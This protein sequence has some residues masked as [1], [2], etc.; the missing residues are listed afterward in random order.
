M[1]YFRWWKESQ[2]K[3]LQRARSINP[4]EICCNW[5]NGLKFDTSDLSR[6]L[7]VFHMTFYK[8]SGDYSLDI[9]QKC[10]FFFW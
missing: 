5:L 4:C 10:F 1:N 8:I 6:Q 9:P 7:T 3:G 2:M